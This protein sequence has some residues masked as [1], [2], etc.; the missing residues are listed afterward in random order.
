MPDS[1]DSKPHPVPP[2]AFGDQDAPPATLPPPRRDRGCLLDPLRLLA[3]S[4][5][6]P[7]AFLRGRYLPRELRARARH[8]GRRTLALQRGIVPGRYPWGVL[9]V[10]L[11]YCWGILR[12]S[13]GCPSGIHP[14][15]ID[16]SS[17][18]DTDVATCPLR[19]FHLWPIFPFC[20]CPSIALSSSAN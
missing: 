20:V 6:S 5:H 19:Y 17:T 9:R 16:V 13:F 8:F 4:Y 1:R 14:C 2:V 18:I 7:T 11:G 15:V 12:V 3:P 10:P